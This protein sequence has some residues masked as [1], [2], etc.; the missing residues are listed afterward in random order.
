[1]ENR[2][3]STSVHTHTRTS[4]NGESDGVGCFTPC[5]RARGHRSRGADAAHVRQRA[6]ARAAGDRQASASTV[7]PWRA[8]ELRRVPP[9][10][11][12]AVRDR[13]Q[14]ARRLR[15][16][17]RSGT[18][19]P[20]LRGRFRRRPRTPPILQS[21]SPAWRGHVLL[22]PP[23]RT[24][25]LCPVLPDYFP[26]CEGIPTSCQSPKGSLGRGTSRPL[27]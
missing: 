26:G 19:R 21:L 7:A 5:S 3:A 6:R 25:P 15:C 1:M 12:V 23:G 10:C 16:S 2:C 22:P 8:E 17:R 14:A 20:R 18:L 11:G 24:A 27:K 9:V 13:A 4:L